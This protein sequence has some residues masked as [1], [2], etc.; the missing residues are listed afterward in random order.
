MKTL[1]SIVM[2]TS[3]A[4]F[5][6]SIL[7]DEGAD[8]Y[9]A[10]TCNTCHGT[11]AKS[12]IAPNYPKLAGQNKD[13]LVQQIKDIRDGNRENGQSAVMK[14]IVAALSDDEIEKISAYIAG[15]E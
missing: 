1:L 11:D 7:A 14:A 4:T 9:T 5:S 15:L 12:P 2:V 8:L 10:K 3:L 6:S 13:Y